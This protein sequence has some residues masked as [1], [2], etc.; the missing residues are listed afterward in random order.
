M[1]WSQELSPVEI[2]GSQ[3][4]Q[5][6]GREPGRSGGCGPAAVCLVDASPGAAELVSLGV[7]VSGAAHVV[8]HSYTSQL[9]EAQGLSALCPYSSNPRDTRVCVWCL[10]LD[11]PCFV[12]QRS[13]DSFFGQALDYTGEAK[14]SGMSARRA[15]KWGL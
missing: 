1:L 15:P 5:F 9:Q 12:L 14:L 2:L 3:G 7:P 13:E 11:S 10:V 8:L 4:L 6:C